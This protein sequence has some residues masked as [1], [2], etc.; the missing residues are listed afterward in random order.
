MCHSK[1]Y[2]S[3]L[4]FF[5]VLFAPLTPVNAA[6]IFSTNFAQAPGKVLKN[7][8]TGVSSGLP[9]AQFI[10]LGNSN[11]SKTVKSGNNTV[12]RLTVGTG[13][14]QDAIIVTKSIALGFSG[15]TNGVR[16][17]I[18]LGNKDFG[19]KKCGNG[20][21][22]IYLLGQDSSGEIPSSLWE[23]SNVIAIKFNVNWIGLVM[24]NATRK[25]SDK[26]PTVLWSCNYKGNISSLDLLL[27]QNNYALAING[28][29]GQW[30]SKGAIS[31]LLKL[32][33]PSA[34]TQARLGME[35]KQGSKPM[36][37]F[38]LNIKSLQVETIETS[39]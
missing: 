11:W 36:K 10:S 19:S 37:P 2:T 29:K 25:R 26:T 1:L 13:K 23:A 3:I 4:A 34:F 31:G 24:K 33:A 39:K 14:Y 28:I 18:E 15:Q 32:K 22:C 12:L 35:L 7:S 8:K 21:A 6:E 5:A 16:Y 20:T 17:R 38:L 27:T 30:N 9:A